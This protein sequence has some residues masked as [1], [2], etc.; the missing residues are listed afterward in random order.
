MKSFSCLFPL[1]KPLFKKTG[2][3][4]S[5]P[6][7]NLILA[8]K[9]EISLFLKIC[10]WSHSCIDFS[11]V[12]HQ[13][14]LAEAV[15]QTLL[16]SVNSFKIMKRPLLG[17]GET[18]VRLYITSSAFYPGLACKQWRNNESNRFQTGSVSWFICFS[19]QP[20]LWT[21]QHFLLSISGTWE[22]K[23]LLGVLWSNTLAVPISIWSA[24][25]FPLF[26]SCRK[27]YTSS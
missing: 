6:V 17:K 25:L 23:G 27:R 5:Q 12:A 14:L 3:C 11:R 19:W 9:C 10:F 4:I 2:H 22:N 21:H 8:T 26:P 20:G 13:E 7:V 1:I 15:A 16:Y 18:R 24:M